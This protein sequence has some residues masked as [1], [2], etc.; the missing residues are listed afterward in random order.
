M[1]AELLLPGGV[2]SMTSAA[3]DRLLKSGSGDATLLYLHLLRR[4][5]E[6]SPEGARQTLGWTG[7]RLNTAYEVLA[8]LG[9]VDKSVPSTPSR[10]PPEPDAPPDYSSADIARE[11]ESGSAFRHMAGELERRLG[12]VL[13]SSDLKILLSVYDYL[14][15]PA[16]VILMLVTWCTEDIEHKYGAGRKPTLSQIR[17]EAFIWHRLGVDTAEAADAHIRALSALRN[18]ERVILPLLGI[19]GR[20]P[21]ETERKYIS[22]WVDMGFDDEAIALAYEKTVLK[23]QSLNWPYMN[24]ILKSWHQKNLH[25]LT[26]VEAGDSDYRRNRPQPSAPAKP[27]ESRA[28]LRED[29]DWMDRFLAETDPKEGK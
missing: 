16:E 7:D 28:R 14:S 13:S 3:A 27:A 5:G 25:T 11:L 23:K 21:V 20:A 12:K 18:R 19:G 6:Y 1:G 22:S 26:Q 10:T 24:S 8:G 2:V 17:K 29:M 15:L 4:G 9:L